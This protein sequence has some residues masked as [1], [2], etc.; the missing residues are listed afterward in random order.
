[1]SQKS[2]QAYAIMMKDSYY[3]APD[4]EVFYH[5][6]T[7]DARPSTAAFAFRSGWYWRSADDTAGPF[8][9]AERAEE[10]CFAV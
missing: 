2:R 4:V 9:T 5:R 7:R 1:M 8:S 6:G 3:A 10:D